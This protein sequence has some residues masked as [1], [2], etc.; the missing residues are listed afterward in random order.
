MMDWVTVVAEERFQREFPA[1]ALAEV[2][3]TTQDGRSLTSGVLSARWDPASALPTDDELRAKFRWLAAPVVGEE[4]ARQ[5][6]SLVW[7]R[8]EHH[9]N[10]FIQIST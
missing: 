8:E 5:I 2:T 1:K 3:I 4:K 7:R 9:L 6:E 10:E